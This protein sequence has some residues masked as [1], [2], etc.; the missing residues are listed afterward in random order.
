MPGDRR[1]LP[2]DRGA[3]RGSHGGRPPKFDRAGYRERHAVECGVKRLKRH[4]AVATGYDE[5]AVRFDVTV[6]VTAVNEWL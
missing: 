1:R 4:R 5:L 2:A 3:S 6:L